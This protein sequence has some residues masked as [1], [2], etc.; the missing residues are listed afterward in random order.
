MK[1]RPVSL[2]LTV[3]SLTLASLSVGQAKPVTFDFKDPKEV[4]NVVFQ[5]DAP[6]EA[7]NGTANG[8]TGTVTVDPENPAKTK[9]RIVVATDSLTVPNSVMRGHMLG[10]KWLDAKAH[11]KITFDIKSISA[12][13]KSKT[14]G[15]A[16]VTGTFTL[17]GVSKEIT[18]EA[19]V[20][21][22]PDKL[23]ERSGG[24]ME[25]DLL[26][27]RSKFTINRSDYKIQPG[28]N[29]DKVSEE[30]EISLSIAGAAPR[31]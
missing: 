21:H 28:E 5:L 30:I 20:T 18:V 29:T 13:K 23:G 31:K 17:H 27:I 16:Q 2:T 4:N 8:I 12:V 7:I 6:L 22:L 1:I 10:K 14:T 11:P 25:G 24:K 3:L 26:V 15:S 9:G 19:R